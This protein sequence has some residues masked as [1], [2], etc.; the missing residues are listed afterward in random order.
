[1]SCFLR[2]VLS[3]R[4]SGLSGRLFPFAPPAQ[5]DSVSLQAIPD[6]G[7]AAPDAALCELRLDGGERDIR[8]A[9]DEVSEPFGFPVERGFDAH[10]LRLE[11]SGGPPL[12][13]PAHRFAVADAELPGGGLDLGAAG[14][15]VHQACPEIVGLS[16]KCSGP[17]R[18]VGHLAGQQRLDVPP[19]ERKIL[20]VLEAKGRLDP[21]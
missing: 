12:R 4:C 17:L 1:M 14:Y 10:L 5:F 3:F 9:G 18:L 8:L 15:R 13:H 19:Q 21:I 20:V 16:G 11:D 2:V 7:L 6:G